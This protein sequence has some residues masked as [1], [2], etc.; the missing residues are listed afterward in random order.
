MATKRKH[1]RFSESIGVIESDPERSI[2][3][4][5][6]PIPLRDLFVPS[7]IHPVACYAVLGYLDISAKSLL[8]LFFS[9]PITYGGLSLSPSSIGACLGLLGLTDG[10][11]QLLFLAKLVD[12]MGP[13]R[14]FC[15]AI[16]CYIPLML[17][18]PLMSWIVQTRGVVDTWIYACI[19]AQLA[20]IV[21]WDVAFG[22]CFNIRLLLRL[23]GNDV[24]VWD[25][26]GVALSFCSV[27]VHVHHR[28]RAVK[29]YARVHQW[30]RSDLG[31]DR[32]GNR[33][34]D[35]DLHVCVLERA[36]Y[37]GRPRSVCLAHASGGRFQMVHS[38]GSSG[39]VSCSRRGVGVLVGI[40]LS[41]NVFSL[42]IFGK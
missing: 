3:N 4:T 24:D 25:P 40:F 1:R 30:H 37:F 5:K 23:V 2:P 16:L 35:G 39:R 7:I 20:L 9:T 26:I 34:C 31:V 42:D 29:E 13:K 32:T 21:F 38:V 8:P 27:C 36:P 22:T 6:L 18:F 28:L 11:F 12:W 19:V 33:T 14:L 15:R 17:L 10:I 41:L